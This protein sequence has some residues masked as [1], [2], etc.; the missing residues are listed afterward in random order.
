MTKGR[1][2]LFTRMI[3]FKQRQDFSE[4]EKMGTM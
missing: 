2:H 4:M 1:Y 3:I